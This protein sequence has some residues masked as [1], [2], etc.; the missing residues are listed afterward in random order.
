MKSGMLSGT[1][2]APRILLRSTYNGESDLSSTSDFLLRVF[3]LSGFVAR[4]LSGFNIARGGRY[5]ADKTATGDTNSTG[6]ASHYSVK[7]ICAV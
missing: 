3:N 6:S 1:P 4:N 5:E 7:P 2:T